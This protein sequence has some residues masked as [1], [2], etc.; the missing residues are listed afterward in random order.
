MK[1]IKTTWGKIFEKDNLVLFNEFPNILNKCGEYEEL[2]KWFDSDDN[3]E[4][5]VYQWYIIPNSFTVEWLE[6]FCPE[7]AEDVHFSET[8]GQDVL[9]VYHCG[10]G[11]DAVR[12]TLE[13]DDSDEDLYEL[14]KK[15]YHDELP[16]WVKRNV[17]NEYDK[18]EDK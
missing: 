2:Y 18:E 4:N 17:L 12:A 7:I 6:R 15:T 5:E 8:I 14:Y 3:G 13:I 1:K 9:A 11:W 10:T 16:E